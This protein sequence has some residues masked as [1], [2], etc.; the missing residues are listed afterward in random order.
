[1]KS[2]AFLLI[3]AVS[4]V[5]ACSSTSGDAPSLA[6]PD[7]GPAPRPCASPAE[8]YT[9][10][11]PR[12]D[13][14]LDDLAFDPSHR[15]DYVRAVL[16]RRYPLG[17]WVVDVGLARG[18]ARLRGSCVTT[19][20]RDAA[21][22]EDVVRRIPTVVHECGH[23]ADTEGATGVAVYSV[24]PDVELRCTGG[25]ARASGGRT[26]PRS[27]L[28]GDAFAKK[29]PP[30]GPDGRTGTCDMYAHLY[31]D[32][33][34]SNA[35]FERGDLGFEYLLEEAL[36][37]VQSL[38][39]GLALVERDP[40]QWVSHRD[41]VLTH[42]WYVARYLRHARVAEPEVHTFLTED[43]CWRRAILTVWDRSVFYLEAT[44]DESSLGLDD[45]ELASLVSDPE[46]TKEIDGLRARECR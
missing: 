15:E 31:F 36:Q 19:F 28:R 7:L 13:L 3:T 27:D 17:R 30:C 5:V 29:R 35:T 25:A 1:M 8:R 39:A 23:Y 24:R 33:D 26:F 20:L 9:E 16:E 21:R 4:A 6:A 43:P 41:G 12:W 40:G 38:A 14:P 44:K 45:A 22:P 46:L 2:R 37:Y 34:A 11:L 10:P 42:M 18:Q 32:G